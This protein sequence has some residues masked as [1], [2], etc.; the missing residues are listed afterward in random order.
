[1]IASG[2]LVI[3]AVAASHVASVKRVRELYGSQLDVAR[4]ASE[5]REREVGGGASP[6]DTMQ[7][8]A[9]AVA[10]GEDGVAV[11]YAV[12]GAQDQL[13]ASLSKLSAGD[14]AQ[15]AADLARVRG[16]PPTGGTWSTADPF[17][18]ELTRLPSGLWKIE[19]F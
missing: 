18:V 19:R 10:S 14:R 11:S 5:E 4:R 7:K 13:R 15:L 6:A 17:Y 1:M 2:A 9:A 8:F 12:R 3:A 16:G